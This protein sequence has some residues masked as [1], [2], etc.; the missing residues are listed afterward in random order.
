M[1]EDA[2]FEVSVTKTDLGSKESILAL[3]EYATGKGGTL[4]VYGD[5]AEYDC[6]P[7]CL[8]LLSVDIEQYLECTSHCLDVLKERIINKIIVIRIR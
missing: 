8:C 5:T 1:L 7:V 6:P 4:S 2:G 3:V